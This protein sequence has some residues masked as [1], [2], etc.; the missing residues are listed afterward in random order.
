M[1]SETGP[2]RTASAAPSPTTTRLKDTLKLCKWAKK[3]GAVSIKVEGV[4]ILF[5]PPDLEA[6]SHFS[7][8]ASPYGVA[9]KANH[10]WLA[11]TTMSYSEQ[12]PPPATSKPRAAIS[13]EHDHPDV[14]ARDVDAWANQRPLG[15]R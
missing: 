6:A 7:T 8:E 14:Y 12:S 3:N 2:R 15:R 11:E 5:P 1:P 9:D 13:S 10:P 4:E